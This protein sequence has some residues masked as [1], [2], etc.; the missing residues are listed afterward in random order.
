MTW[1]SNI[2]MLQIEDLDTGETFIHHA[3]VGMTIEHLPTTPGNFVD[4]VDLSSGELLTL[5]GNVEVFP[6]KAVLKFDHPAG[7]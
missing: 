2:S 7:M 5:R 3:I 4:Y 1:D 6:F